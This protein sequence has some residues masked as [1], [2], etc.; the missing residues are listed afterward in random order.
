MDES[1]WARSLPGRMPSVLHRAWPWLIAVGLALYGFALEIAIIGDVP[2]VTDP[3]LALNICWL[4]L[5]ASLLAQL[6]ALVGASAPNRDD[7]P[8]RMRAR[9]VAAT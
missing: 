6:G 8:D 5:A 7:R 3:E 1:V 2:G 4:A 9:P